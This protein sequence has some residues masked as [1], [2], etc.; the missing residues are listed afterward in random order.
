MGYDTFGEQTHLRDANNNVKVTAYDAGGRP[1]TETAP[2]CTAPGT[3]TAITPVT[4]TEYDPLDQVTASVNATGARTTYAYDQL[5]DL[6]AQV[7][8]DGGKS[9]YSYDTAGD[10]LSVTDPVGAVTSATYDF[11]GRQIT[12][13]DQLKTPAVRNLTTTYG[14]STAGFPNKTSSPAG[15]VSSQ[16]TNAAGEV[17]T[18][19]DGAGNLTRYGYDYSGQVSSVTNADSTKTI[20]SYDDAGN[21]VKSVDY[22]ATGAALRTSTIAYDANGQLTKMTDPR[23]AVSTFDYDA[24]GLVTS[25]SQKIDASS[26]IETSFGYDAAGNRTRFTDGRGNKSWST[27]NSWNLQEAQIEP[28]TPAYPNLND[29]TFTVSYDANGQAVTSRAPGNV[30]VSNTYDVMGRLTGATGTGAEVATTARAFTY[31]EAG[32][33]ITA[34]AG[35]ATET[36]GYDERDA[37]LS[38]KG[39][40]GDSTFNYA[41][42][43]QLVSRSDAAGLT[44]YRYDSAG[45]LSA[46]D[47]PAT[48]STIGL[49]YRSVNLVDSISYGGANKRTFSYDALHRLTGDTMKTAAGAAVASITYGYDLGDNL[50]SKKTAG[51]SGA[52]T[53]TYTY[54]LTNRLTSWDDGTKKTAYGYDASGNRT[55]AGALTYTYDARNELLSDGT[56][57]YAYSARGTQS[58]VTTGT[59]SS[60][61]AFD[62]FGQTISQGDLRY[63]Y[64]ALGRMIKAVNGPESTTM[65]FSGTGNTIANDGTATYTRD[66]EDGLVAASTM[67]GTTKTAV[68]AWTDQHDDLV[69]QFGA[70]GATLTKS[71][72]YDP[73]GNL[74]TGK[75]LLGN[76]GFQSG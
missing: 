50:T 42:D 35:T 40:S 17:V 21:R 63:S 3:S 59:G 10:Q 15:V 28:S 4:R 12:Q 22:D 76:L 26:S 30:A 61:V 9:T 38:A 64:D 57:S 65:S 2:S 53:N 8:A 37:L 11:R 18:A 36:F 49:T 31:D 19:T 45:R 46:M 62:A 74:T 43:G 71:V 55:S 69:G 68:L 58:K 60:T 33:T 70:S 25:E 51:F 32:R 75:N 72:A 6:T 1:V 24:R 48:G 23:G 44:R 34:T 5:G 13:T 66:P 7:N 39:A 16:T 52:A 41:D 54:D 27:Y 14:F 56:K 73:W 29:R 67:V 47:D 20:A